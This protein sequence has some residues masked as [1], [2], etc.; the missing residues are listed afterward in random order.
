MEG[1]ENAALVIRDDAGNSSH[2]SRVSEGV[3][4]Q[5]SAMADVTSGDTGPVITWTSVT[6][7]TADMSEINRLNKYNDQNV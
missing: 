4:P 6:I 7:A 5:V 2:E 3:C 1:K